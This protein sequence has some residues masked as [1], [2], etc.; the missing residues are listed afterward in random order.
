MMKGTLIKTIA[1]LFLV[2]ILAP[3]GNSQD[4]NFSQYYNVP[5]YYNPAMTGLYTGIRARF[6][7][8]DQYP[9]LPDDFKGY[10]FSV[11][12]GD[13]RLPG[14]GGIGLIF[15]TD[16]EGIAFIRN[17]TVGIDLSVRIQLAKNFVTQM[18]IKV[19]Y[20]Q[21][22][23]NWDDFVFGDQLDPKYGYINEMSKFQH[24]EYD[25]VAAPDFGFGIVLQGANDRQTATGT[26]GFSIDHLFSPDMAFL[27]TST[28]RIPKKWVV[29]AD[30]I[31]TIGGSRYNSNDGLK[32]NPGFIY[33]RQGPF[34]TFQ[35]GTNFY[36][37]NIYLGAFFKSIWTQLFQ[38]AV[39]LTAGYRVQFT[40]ETSL[41]F[42]YSYDLIT[43]TA[44]SG[45]G[46]AHEVT[47]VFE[48]DQDGL[49]NSNR[50]W[51]RGPSK[52]GKWG[53]KLECQEF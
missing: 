4:I 34:T 48:F 42:C 24:P 18:G 43:S 29:T 47:L 50:G 12:L 8:R 5:N 44:L 15:N 35:F 20:I 16:D 6:D 17:L 51:G 53:Q 39:V 22:T 32:I 30:G 33:Q 31:F 46:G 40:E 26:L 11:E 14:S 10:Y 19:A 25:R 21:K 1:A 37:Y 7:F 23:L 36:K 41:K 13:R 2:L 28:D 3:P 52:R 9:V 38:G 45:T 27:T 49:F